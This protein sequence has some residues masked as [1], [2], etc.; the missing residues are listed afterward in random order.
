ML[1]FPCSVV[2]VQFVAAGGC[3]TDRSGHYHSRVAGADALRV[4]R[5]A[6]ITNRNRTL[7]LLR[8]PDF[9]F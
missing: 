2:G 7:R 5:A 9:H 8:S 1:R 3:T 4:A 6:G